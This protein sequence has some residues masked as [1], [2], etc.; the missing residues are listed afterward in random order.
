MD[1]YVSTDLKTMTAIW[2]G[3]DSVP[4]AVAD[5]RLLLTGGRRLTGDIQVA[6]P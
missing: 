6:R 1:L 2:M 3:M 4:A 5:E